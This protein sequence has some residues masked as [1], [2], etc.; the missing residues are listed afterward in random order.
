MAGSN[1]TAFTRLQNSISKGTDF[2]SKSLK[3]ALLFNPASPEAFSTFRLALLSKKIDPNEL[4]VMAALLS[5]EVDNLYLRYA[6]LGLRYGANPNTYIKAKFNFGEELVEIPIHLAKHLWDVTPRSREESIASDLSTFGDYDENVSNDRVEARFQDKQ[7]AALDILSMMAIRGLISDSQ[8]TSAALLTKLNINAT[9]FANDHPEFFGSVY[10]SIQTDD[11]LGSIYADEIK[12]FEQWKG[13]LQ[14]AYG[15]NPERNNRIIKYSEWLDIVDVLTL[16]DVYGDLEKL[17]D[18]FMFQDGESLKLILPRMQDLGLIGIEN[19]T[20]A[21]YGP[22]QKSNAK[23]LELI[24]FDWCIIYYNQVALDI[25]LEVG[26][27]PEYS[28]RSQ[29]IRAARVVCAKYP[30]QCQLLNNMTVSYV[31]EGYGLDSEQ[32]QELSFSKATLAAVKKEYSAPAWQSI[33]KVP[34]GEVNADIKEMAR[35]VGI[36]VGAGKQQIC[37]TFEAMAKGNPASLKKASYEVNRNM[38]ITSTTNSADIVSGRKT[39]NQDRTLPAIGNT[40]ID[41]LQ[42]A[43]AANKKLPANKP[44]P[45]STAKS[46][47]IAAN[48]LTTNN[49]PTSVSQ[50]QAP[51]CANNDTLFRPIE[52]YPAIDRVSYSDGHSTW[53][54][55]SENFQELL[56]T[57]I[58]RWAN[59]PSGGMGAPIPEEVLLEMRQKLDI[60]ER[61]QLPVD[62][63]S[64]SKGVDKIFDSNPASHE[65]YYERETNRRLELFYEFA[66]D[67]GIDRSIFTKL[68]SPDYQ[69]LADNILSSTTRINVNRSSPGLALRDFANALMIEITNFQNQDEV[70]RTLANILK[71]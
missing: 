18:I 32:L 17:E 70:G 44:M 48:N 15:V 33:C 46:A 23:R 41:E 68:R 36:P 6:G 37:N 69:L 60:I 66:E 61:A 54:F 62:P 71:Q 2:N 53:C 34:T 12:Y 27:V 3:A 51:I 26:V 29:T 30:L 9:K 43:A 64:I 11:V 31:K 19:D 25:L 1:N 58:N 21:R 47:N 13:S 22:E 5:V 42:Q 10:G 63:A 50:L 59:N 16:T 24:M 20:T 45:N 56:D 28:I 52:D 57:G 67:Y 55:T 4:F 7:R 8:I 14:N 38:I 35:E 65:A 40:T 39:L 49:L